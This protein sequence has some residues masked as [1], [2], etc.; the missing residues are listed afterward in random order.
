MAISLI[1]KPS[2][3]L[4]LPLAKSKSSLQMG[5]QN[6]IKQYFVKRI[7]KFKWLDLNKDL[8]DQLLQLDHRILIKQPIVLHRNECKLTQQA[9]LP[10]NGYL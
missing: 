6:L 5:L 9:T 4:T 1:L 8:F 3:K 7:L 2:T 10:V